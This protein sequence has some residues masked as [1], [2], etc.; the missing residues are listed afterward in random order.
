VY[1]YA[2]VGAPPGCVAKN[3]STWSCAPSTPGNY[4]VEVF[5][6]DTAGGSAHAWENLTVVQPSS[7]GPGSGSSL[8]TFPGIEWLLLVGI[9]GGALAGVGLMLWFWKRRR[10]SEPP[11]G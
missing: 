4:S 3:A 10:P 9:A 11:S 1:S 2:F 6:N 8:G 7:G 5:A